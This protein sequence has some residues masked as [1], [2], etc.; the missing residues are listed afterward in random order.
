MTGTSVTTAGIVCPGF[1]VVRDEPPDDHASKA[2]V[3][4]EDE[5]KAHLRATIDGRDLTMELEADPACVRAV[6]HHTA[7]VL[8][9]WGLNGHIPDATLVVSELV[10]NALCHAAPADTAPGRPILLRLVRR[11]QDLLCLVA[12]ASDRPPALAEADRRNRAWPAA[13]GRPQPPVGLDAP[14]ASTGQM[15]LGAVIAPHRCVAMTQSAFS[16]SVTTTRESR[17]PA[18]TH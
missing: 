16:S 17:C 3:H 4:V 18:A 12:D 15:G 8:A 7:A 11:G 1:G 2:H 10:T 5:L 9:A 14:A 13:G 6:R